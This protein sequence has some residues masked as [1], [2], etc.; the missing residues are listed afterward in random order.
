MTANSRYW[1]HERCSWVTYETPAATSVAGGSSGLAADA[2][3]EQR[4]DDETIPAESV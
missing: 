4:T 3:P 2:L 1:D